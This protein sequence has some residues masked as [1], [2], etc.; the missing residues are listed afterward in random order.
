[1]KSIYNI[2]KNWRVVV[3]TALLLVALLCIMATSEWTWIIVLIKVIGFAL[4]WLVNRLWNRWEADGTIDCLVGMFKDIEDEKDLADELPYGEPEEH[5]CGK[6][7]EEE[8]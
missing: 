6:D 5:H 2:L 3:L 8:R 4:C 1:M 7:K